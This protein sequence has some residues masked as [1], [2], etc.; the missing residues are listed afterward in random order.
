MKFLLKKK[1]LIFPFSVCVIIY[2]F[3]F[4]VHHKVDGRK[5]KCQANEVDKI[6][7]LCQKDKSGEYSWPCSL[8]CTE[9][10]Y[11]IEH[12]Y[13]GHNQK[14]LVM[15][16]N[17]TFLGRVVIKYL[18]PGKNFIQNSKEEFDKSGK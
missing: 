11:T 8:F 18:E 17:I 3:S 6:R 7:E 9:D 16:A 13:H 12:C 5:D 2:C 1:C 14:K 4:S 10:L 15:R